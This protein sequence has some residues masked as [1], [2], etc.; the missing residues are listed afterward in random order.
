MRFHGDDEIP[1]MCTEE[2]RDQGCICSIPFP[3][4]HDIDP[5]EP[6]A[7]KYCPLHGWERDPD[8]EYDR[9]RDNKLMEDL[10]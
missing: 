8:Y 9:K 6:K 2:A 4:S 5:P 1:E 3:G 10:T 7:D